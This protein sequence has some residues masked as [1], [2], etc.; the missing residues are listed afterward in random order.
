MA[1]ID[2]LTDRPIGAVGRRIFGS[3]T[4]HRPDAVSVYNSKREVEGKYVDI[5]FGPHSFTLLEVPLAG[6]R[7]GERDQRIRTARPAGPAER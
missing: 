7:A 2:V 3:F 5:T 6:D 4:E 1:R